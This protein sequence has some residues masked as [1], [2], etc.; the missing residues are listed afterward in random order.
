MPDL[1]FNSLDDNAISAKMTK[2]TRID[3]ISR[4]NDGKNLSGIPLNRLK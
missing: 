2:S 4:R 1:K 3:Y